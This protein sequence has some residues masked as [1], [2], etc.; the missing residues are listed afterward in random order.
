MSHS[1]YAKD[2]KEAANLLIEN[3]SGAPSIGAVGKLFF[4]FLVPSR[5]FQWRRKMVRG[6]KIQIKE[7]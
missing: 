6:E 2:E 7:P 4:R 5:V 1:L 3:I